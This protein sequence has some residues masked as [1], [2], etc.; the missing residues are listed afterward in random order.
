MFIIDTTN[1]QVQITLDM[2]KYIALVTQYNSCEIDDFKKREQLTRDLRAH[3]QELLSELYAPM[4]IVNFF[5]SLKSTITDTSSVLFRCLANP[6]SHLNKPLAFDCISLYFTE[7][8]KNS[9]DSFAVK[10]IRSLPASTI[11]CINIQ[12]WMVNDH[13]FFVFKDN[14]CGF[15]QTQLDS[16][17]QFKTNCC[18]KNK[19]ARTQD[20]TRLGGNHRALRQIRDYL[21]N[22]TIRND[23]GIDNQICVV[24]PGDSNLRLS[25]DEAGGAILE[26]SSRVIIQNSLEI[27]DNPS[28]NAPPVTEMI[29]LTLPLRFQKKPKN[30]SNESLSSAAGSGFFAPT[31]TPSNNSDASPLDPSVLMSPVGLKHGTV[32]S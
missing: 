1:E 31:P 20:P 9:M 11:L 29:K 27:M 15:P 16:L 10:N 4:F 30:L 5:H 2:A 25:N 6:F 12:A 18:D 32:G 21:L 23:H 7:I 28:E 26:L 3:K 22:G 13:M 14:G 24:T 17:E 8:I 19:E